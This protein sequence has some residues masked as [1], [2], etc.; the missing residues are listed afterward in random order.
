VVQDL[1]TLMAVATVVQ[2]TEADPTTVMMELLVQVEEL[3][4][5]LVTAVT[6]VG[7]YLVVAELQELQEL[8]VA[9]AV[10]VAVTE[11]KSTLL[12]AVA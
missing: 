6:V 11:V 7:L 5:I 4:V 8:A 9:V 1:Q 10:A 2:A 3:A 12:A